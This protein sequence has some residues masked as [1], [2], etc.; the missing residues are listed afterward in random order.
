[1]KDTFFKSAPQPSFPSSEEGQVIPGLPLPTFEEN[2]V[3]NIPQIASANVPDQ[4]HPEKY[5]NDEETDIEQILD[6]PVFR[7]QAVNK[8]I[9]NMNSRNVNY[10]IFIYS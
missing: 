4:S 2:S 3:P 1:M 6:N 10:P 9:Q 5:F 8:F 7:F